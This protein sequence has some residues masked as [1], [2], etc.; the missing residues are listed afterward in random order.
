MS[1]EQTVLKAVQQAQDILA[2][3]IDPGTPRGEQEN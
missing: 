2:H 3:F 1:A